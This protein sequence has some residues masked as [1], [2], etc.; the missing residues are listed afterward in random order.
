ML[1]M[2]LHCM[3]RWQDDVTP[4]E[5]EEWQMIARQASHGRSRSSVNSSQDLESAVMEKLLKTAERPE[6]IEA[7]IRKATG[8]TFIDFWR[9]RSKIKKIDI[10]ALDQDED[11]QFA[12][13]VTETLMGPKTAYL[14]QESIQ[15]ILSYLPEKQQKMVLM[16]AA[17]F[18]NLEIAD[19]LGYASSNAVSNQLRRIRQEITERLEAARS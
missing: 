19:E 16:S 14:L 10:D 13:A 3:S 2:Y 9:T 4:E 17:G 15:E 8:T 7:W 5:W 1:L 11:A 18:S 6:N 12:R